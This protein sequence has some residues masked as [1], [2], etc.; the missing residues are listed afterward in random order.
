MNPS[1]NQ[2]A[3][4]GHITNASNRRKNGRQYCFVTESVAGSGKSTTLCMCIDKAIEIYPGA[5][6]LCLQFNSHIKDQLQAKLDGPKY[7]NVDISTNHSAGMRVLRE[8][9]MKPRVNKRK[10]WDL[11]F[12]IVEQNVE[13]ILQHYISEKDKKQG[14]KIQKQNA[15]KRAA[16][17]LTELCSMTMNTLTN[18]K[19]PEKIL[20]MVEKHQCEYTH[21]IILEYIRPAIEMSIEMAQNNGEISFDDMIYLP[22]KLRLDHK[23]YDFIFIDELQDLNLGQLMLA[24]NFSDDDTIVGGFGDSKQAI[25]AWTGAMSDG[26][27]QF[28]E[29]TNARRL[30]LSVCYRC[31]SKVLELARIL[32][33][34]IEDRPNCPPG[35]VDIMDKSKIALEGR[36]K[37]MVLCRITAPLVSMC[38]HFIRQRKPAKVKGKD[39]GKK[40]VEIYEEASDFNMCATIDQFIGVLNGPGGYAETQRQKAITK[41]WNDAKVEKMH[42]EL[43][44]ITVIAEYLSKEGGERHHSFIRKEIES[45]FSD[46][47]GDNFIMLSSVHRSKGLEANRVF[48]LEFHKMPFT[49]PGK[50]QSAEQYQQE[51]NLIYVAITRA[52]QELYIQ[53]DNI[54]NVSELKGYL[55]GLT[56]GGPGAMMEHHSIGSD[57]YA[58]QAGAD[59]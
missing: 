1:E 3:I 25:M 40:L 42:D 2:Q 46:D 27:D 22:T 43:E 21:P 16:I 13:A 58:W 53:A 23:R 29:Y 52:M 45:L 38:I 20:A 47:I 55:N 7:R 15:F 18:F 33:P 41:K 48:I 49:Y 26:M 59:E 24:L 5:K 56:N 8:A 28:L 4:L 57:P 6:I 10:M 51:L 39:I 17:Q 30:K 50:Q 9:R 19:K 37:D 11:C 32:V 35:I 54:D 14:E 34:Q 36:A 12:S 31:P 44:C